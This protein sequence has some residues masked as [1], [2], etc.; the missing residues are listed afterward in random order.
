MPTPDQYNEP[1]STMHYGKK[2]IEIES[3]QFQTESDK[4]FAIA[5]IKFH[6]YILSRY[7]I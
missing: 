4:R 1:S 2:K 6:G 3:D 5:H 7:I